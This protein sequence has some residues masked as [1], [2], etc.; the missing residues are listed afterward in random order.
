MAGRL[1]ARVLPPHPGQGRGY[2]HLAAVIACRNPAPSR[3]AA[4]GLFI[5]C[6]AQQKRLA[7][8]VVYAG[9][10][11]GLVFKV[12]RFIE[13]TS[14]TQAVGLRREGGESQRKQAAVRRAQG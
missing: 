13:K 6:P 7:S 5:A 8:E 12:F 9:R 14:V 2:G 3:D 11:L 4:A 10:G 1:P